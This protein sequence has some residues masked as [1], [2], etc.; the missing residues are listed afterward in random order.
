M[1]RLESFSGQQQII[2]AAFKVPEIRR[3]R[4]AAIG[5]T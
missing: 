2:V 5:V 4:P 3:S 1:G